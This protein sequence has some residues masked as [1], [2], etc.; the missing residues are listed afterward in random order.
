MRNFFM[1]YI[2]I[3]TL[4][5]LTLSLSA[6]D[7]FNFTPVKVRKP[8]DGLKHW[9][10]AEAYRDSHPDFIREKILPQSQFKNSQVLACF[11]DDLYQGDTAD[12][13]LMVLLYGINWEN[14]K[15]TPVLLVHGAA[16]DA[17]RAWVH[18]MSFTTPSTIQYPGFM[19]KFSQAGYPVFAINFSHNH[20]CNYRQAEQIH[21]AIQV[22]KR[23]TGANKVHLL[24]H[25]KGN[26]AASIYVCGGNTVNE[27]YKNFL[28]PFQQDVDVYIQIAAGNKGVDTMFRYYTSNLTV[29]SLNAPAP[30]CFKEALIYGLWQKYYKE[31]IYKSNPGTEIGNYFP[32]QSQLL[33]NLVDDGLGFTPF[34]YT[35]VDANLTMNACYY[36]GTTFYVSS[37][38]IKYAIQEG[39]YTIE[40]INRAGI[41]PSVRLLN[42]YGTNPAFIEIDM[43]FYKIPLTVPDHPSDGAVYVHSAKYIDGL[44]NRG[45]TLLGQKAFDKNHVFLAF[46]DETFYW[47]IRQLGQ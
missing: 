41:D 38:G 23:K 37:Y 29:V 16:D 39:D 7:Q 1:K 17:F 20:G 5:L 12:S 47:I 42:L 25:S 14:C 13:S 2:A 21:N 36:G 3:F 32:G 19:Q 33:Y 11:P 46:S 10:L 34:C 27:N 40:R 26:C 31:D 18:P 28:S 4:L 15:K 43:I 9:E 30:V 6:T 35:P 45:A 24:A 44:L 8:S 22:I